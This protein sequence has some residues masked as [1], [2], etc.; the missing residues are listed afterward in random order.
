MSYACEM[1][2]IENNPCIGKGIKLPKQTDR[3]EKATPVE[4]IRAYVDVMEDAP[5]Q[6]KAFFFLALYSGARKGEVLGLSWDNVNFTDQEITIADNCQYLTG[7]GVLYQTPKSESSARTISLPPEVFDILRQL[8]T[9]QKENR[10]Q[11]GPRWK[12][13]PENPG[14]RYCENHIV[15]NKPCRGFCAKNCKM[16]KDG[17]RVFVN[18][19][20][21]P[22]HPDTSRKNLQKIGAR[23]GLPKITVHQ[24]RHFLVSAAIANGDPITQIA[25]FVGH[26]SPKVT[27]EVYAHEIVRA[28]QAKHLNTDIGSMLKIAK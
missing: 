19:L 18:E 5:L 10:L 23:A 8:Q 3:K 25:G 27:N 16:F 7:K 22:L 2:Y 1:D 12:A 15:C 21:A 11:A 28:G 14:E 4:T 17:N 26:S 6:D 24:L 9:Q 13:N 20:G